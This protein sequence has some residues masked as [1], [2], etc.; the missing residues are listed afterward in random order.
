M[1]KLWGRFF[2][3]MC[4]SQKVQTL[5][6]VASRMQHVAIDFDHLRIAKFNQFVQPLMGCN[7][8][9]SSVDWDVNLQTGHCAAAQWSTNWGILGVQFATAILSLVVY[10]PS[11]WPWHSWD[12]ILD[13]YSRDWS[14]KFESGLN[15]IIAI[16]QK[17]QAVLLPKLFP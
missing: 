8:H 11:K 1:S 2:Q 7:F 13:F 16:V 3:I 4:A 10:E 12:S 9:W 17:V 5:N 6:R 14:P 15:I